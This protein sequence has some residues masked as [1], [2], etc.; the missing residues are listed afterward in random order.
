MADGLRTFMKNIEKQQKSQKVVDQLK[1]QIRL[2]E[3]RRDGYA[4]EER[5]ISNKAKKRCM[6]LKL[7]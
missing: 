4:E 5:N 3:K 2:L 7:P 6:L 1:A